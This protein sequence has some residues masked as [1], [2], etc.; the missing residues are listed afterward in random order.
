[1]LIVGRTEC[2]VMTVAME[3]DV[4]TVQFDD[5]LASRGILYFKSRHQTTYQIEKDTDSVWGAAGVS[6]RMSLLNLESC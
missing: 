2:H 1:M 4:S 5:F 3:M 6:V